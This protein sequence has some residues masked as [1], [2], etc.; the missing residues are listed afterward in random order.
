MKGQG[1]GAVGEVSEEGMCEERSP[2]SRQR[3]RE[4]PKMRM[5]R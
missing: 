3:D 2:L 4:G 1:D 5:Y